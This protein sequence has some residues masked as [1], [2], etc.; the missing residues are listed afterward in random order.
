MVPYFIFAIRAVQQERRAVDRRIQH[1]VALQEIELM[2][3]YEVSPADKV[4]AVNRI[5]PKPQMRHCYRARFLGIVDKISLRV[6]WRFLP[7]DLN[8]ILIRADRSIRAE[9]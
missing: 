3:G 7:D 4:A 6:V 9:P 2:D 8:R 5:G 1:S